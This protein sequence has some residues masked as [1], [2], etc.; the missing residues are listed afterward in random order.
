MLV[1]MAISALSVS[2]SKL[3]RARTV[4]DSVKNPGENSGSSQV[5]LAALEGVPNS[6]ER[7]ES[8]GK[9]NEDADCDTR[10]S[11]LGRVYPADPIVSVLKGGA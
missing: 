5:S 10:V 11:G 7:E 1:C 4:V 3:G 6:R 8:L 2:D 9:D